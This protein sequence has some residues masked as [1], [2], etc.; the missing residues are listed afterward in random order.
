LEAAVSLGLLVMLAYLLFSGNMNALAG[1]QWTVMQT[2]SDAHLS[3]EAAY[4]QRVPFEVFL[5]DESSPPSPWP[6]ADSSDGP[7]ASQVQ[8][9]TMPGGSE[10]TATVY[11]S[12]VPDPSNLVADGGMA[13]IEENPSRMESW[14][15]HAHLVFRIG[16]REYFKSRTVVRTR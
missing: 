7:A 16:E 10:V 8:L 15:L 9:G 14:R 3:F 6:L 2:L 11:R 13:T 4:A 5:D 1:R 12:R